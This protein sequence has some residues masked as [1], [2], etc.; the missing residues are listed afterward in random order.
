MARPTRNFTGTQIVEALVSLG[1]EL[2]RTPTKIEL[3]AKLGMHQRHFE[4]HFETYNDALA[5]AKLPPNI[6]KCGDANRLLDDWGNLARQLGHIPRLAEYRSR[7]KYSVNAYRRV[8]D[9]WAGVARAFNARSGE[10]RK[11][12]DVIKIIESSK[13]RRGGQPLVLS[14]I[15]AATNFAPPTTATYGK[16]IN[17]DFLRNAPV[18]EAGVVYLFGCLAT[19]LGYSV[20]AIQTGFPDC[21]A[22][23]EGKDG[24]LRRVRIEFEFESRN[25]ELHKHDVSGCDVIVCWHHNWKECPLHVVE[26]KKELEKLQKAA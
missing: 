8:F 18:N 24:R 5:A 13:V 26:L 20:E 10:D 17:F 1:A 2:G 7:G 16:P 12:H 6:L 25:F 4:A 21:E 14:D 11:W 3:F 15:D 22:K 9:S 23:R 19:K